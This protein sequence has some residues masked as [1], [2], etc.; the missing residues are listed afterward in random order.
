MK[1]S[2]FCKNIG[3]LI[4][5]LFLVQQLN[6]QK[7]LS[8]TIPKATPE[9]AFIQLNID[10]VGYAGFYYGFFNDFISATYLDDRN[11]NLLSVQNTMQFGAFQQTS[12]D[13][14]LFVQYNVN[15]RYSYR[16]TEKFFIN[17]FSGLGSATILQENIRPRFFFIPG[18]SLGTLTSE[19][20]MREIGVRFHLDLGSG[21]ERWNNYIGFMLTF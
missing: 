15:L 4:P 21:S 13:V 5:A 10:N 20:K 1:N 18:F 3:I 8:E 16:I 19:N 6:A 17:L 14:N 11:R 2:N 12:S 9:F 7:T